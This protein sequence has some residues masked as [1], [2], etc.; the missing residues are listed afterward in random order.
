[1]TD[2]YL[3]DTD[4]CIFL[5]QKKYGITQ[6]IASIGVSNC[7]VSVITV[8]ELKFGAHNSLDYEKHKDDA[9]KIIQ[10]ATVLPIFESLEA[11]G[12]EKHG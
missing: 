11:Y 7:Y 2:K 5:L 1:M 3:L 4:T 12:K 10:L 8:A 9:D 6:K